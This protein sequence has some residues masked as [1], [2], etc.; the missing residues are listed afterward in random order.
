M[1]DQSL[2][3]PIGAWFQFFRNAYSSITESEGSAPA[4]GETTS[5]PSRGTASARSSSA[6]R[7]GKQEPRWETLTDYAKDHLP[8]FGSMPW[9]APAF[10]GREVTADPQLYCLSSM[11]GEDGEGKW[12]DF[13][14]TCLTEQGT[15]YDIS[16]GECR[17]LARQGPVYNP[18]KRQQREDAGSPSES[19]PAP[20]A[21][22]GMAPAGTV[23]DYRP[24][25]RGDIF[26][27]S[28]G[29]DAG[30]TYTGPTTGL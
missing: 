18:Y 17:T 10:D 28:P 14:C 6:S 29:Y 22:A 27:R 4:A 25:S 5:S 26:P 9:T 3:A 11:A 7:D 8:R 21:H 16:Q 23:V 20:V 13:S 30:Q 2:S 12:Q 24:G 19:P 1:L 15:A